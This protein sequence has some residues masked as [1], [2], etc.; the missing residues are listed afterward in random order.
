VHEPQPGYGAA[1]RAGLQAAVGRYVLLADADATYDLAEAAAF[2]AHLEGGADV[3]MGNRFGGM[4]PGSMPLLH[5]YVGNPLLTFLLNLRFRA[6][7][8]DAHC[9]MRAFRRDLLPALDLRT[10]GME[11]ASE[12]VVRCVQLGLDIRQV[13]IGYFPRRGRSKLATFRDGWR[14][15]RF[16]LG[17]RA[18]APR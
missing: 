4:R 15:L 3:V 17:R 5:R 12:H 11:F 2:V 9:G 13:D 10:S 6:G 7:V 14:H 16:L 18:A 8:R 1:C